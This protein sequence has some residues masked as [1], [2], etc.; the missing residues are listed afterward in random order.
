MSQTLGP[1]AGASPEGSCLPGS[2]CSSH[3][4]KHG[5]LPRA[6][7]CFRHYTYTPQQGMGWGAEVMSDK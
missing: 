1:G 2:F 6:W 5:F 4:S 3:S 7:T